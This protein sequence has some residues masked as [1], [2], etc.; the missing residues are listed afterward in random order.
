MENKIKNI[1]HTPGCYIYKNKSGKIIYVGKAKDLKKRVSSY[2]QKK[3][4]D[5]KTDALVK[6]ISNIEYFATDNEIEALLLEARLIRDNRPKYNIDLKDSIRY[7]YLKITDEKFPRLITTRRVDNKGKFFGPYADGSARAKVA[8][9]A[10]KMFKIRACKKMPKQACLQYHIGNCLAPCVGTIT[11][12]NYSRNIKDA[13][14]FL[15]GDI[16]KLAQNLKRQ[17]KL[18]SDKENYE[19]AKIFYDQLKSLEILEER[20]K[21]DLLKKV[22]QDVINL[23]MHENSFFLE[24]FHIKRGTILNKEKFEFKNNKEGEEKI[25]TDFVKQYYSTKDIP[26]E[27]ILPAK[28]QQQDLIKKYLEK[29]GSRK[30]ELLIPQKGIKKELLEMVKNNLILSLNPENQPLFDLKNKLNLKSFPQTIECFDISNIGSTNIVGSMVCFKDG[31]PS[32]DDYRK[33]KIK[34]K[35]TQD[36]FAAMAEIVFRRYKNLKQEKLN[37]PDL[38]IVD[39]GLGQLHSAQ[40]ELK[41]LKLKIPIIGLAKRE[42]NVYTLDNSLSVKL[43]K[44]SESLKLLQRIRDE[45]HRFAV[46]FHRQKRMIS[47]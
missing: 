17:M 5:Y 28:L 21:V 44:K 39:G 18:T 34:N 10:I 2:F 3:D 46:G 35:N 42:E 43:D 11:A 40:N 20:Q 30:V 47:G 38:I 13:E 7:A 24:L 12:E 26:H 25:L 45:A 29:L 27:I 8:L 6:E 41:K 4:H 15:R 14:L 37:L 31:K 9:M 36:D 32:K 19:R 1:P 16:K 23:I 22:N 33:F